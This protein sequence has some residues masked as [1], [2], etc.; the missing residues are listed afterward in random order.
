[1]LYTDGITE[2]CSPEGE[3]YEVERL[4]E[5][6]AKKNND[7]PQKIISAVIEDV[8]RF[9]GGL[10]AKDDQAILVFIVE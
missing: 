5:R 1:M 8:K 4:C 7:D 10:P 6:F 2:A 3:Y 9:A